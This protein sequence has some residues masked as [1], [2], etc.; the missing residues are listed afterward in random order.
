MKT[1]VAPILRSDPA[2]DAREHSAEHGLSQIVISF[3]VEEHFRI[4][5]AAGLELDPSLKSHYRGR[6]EPSM[7][8][9]SN[10]WKMPMSRRRF[11]LWGKSARQSWPNSQ[12][13]PGG[14]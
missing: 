1:A 13:P 8:G 4:E 12:D 5:A 10:N 7:G 9:Y 14:A 6:L 2:H 3:D 11:S